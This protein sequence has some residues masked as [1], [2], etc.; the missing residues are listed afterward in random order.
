MIDFFRL[1]NWWENFLRVPIFDNNL[2]FMLMITS[3]E[4][5]MIDIFRSKI[6]EKFFD[7]T[8]F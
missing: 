8:D 7:D 5:G 2:L 4:G 6:G 1:K 3:R